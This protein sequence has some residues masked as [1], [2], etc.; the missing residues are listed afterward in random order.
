MAPEGDGGSAQG[1]GGPPGPPGRQGERRRGACALLL[2]LPCPAFSRRLPLLH[3][4][5]PAALSTPVANTP[6]AFLFPGQGSQAVGMLSSCKDL[7]AVRAMLNTAQRVLG[8]DL[9]E[10]C[11]NGTHSLS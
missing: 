2:P 1:E 7:P 9:L 3:R 5:Q 10:M 6:V 8:Y 11:I 4:P